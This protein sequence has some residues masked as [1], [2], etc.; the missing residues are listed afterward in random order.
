MAEQPAADRADQIGGREEGPGGDLLGGGVSLGKEGGREIE[1]EGRIAIDV[2]PFDQIADRTDEN[3][4]YAPAR[5]SANVD[6][7]LA[8]GKSVLVS[9]LFPLQGKSSRLARDVLVRSRF[10]PVAPISGI[11]RG[12]RIALLE[13]AA[14]DLGHV[15]RRQI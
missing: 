10:R 9:S 3:R 4:S 1:G 11:H 8:H 5:I 7:S 2:E 14:A 6:E 15:R 12:L 13:P